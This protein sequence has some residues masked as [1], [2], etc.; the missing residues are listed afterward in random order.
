L[1]PFRWSPPAAPKWTLADSEGQNMGS[2][3]FD[4]QPHL[5]IFYLGHGCLHC[6][7]Q[8]QKFAPRIADF[9]NAGIEVV[10]ISSDGEAGLQDSIAN[11]E[12]DLHFRLASNESLDVFKQFRAYDDFEGQ[13]LHGTFLVDGKGRIRWQDISYQPFMDDEF[14]L[15]ESKRL[16]ADEL[17]KKPIASATMLESEA[18][19]QAE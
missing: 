14:L 13:A 17:G 5:I 8:L 2:S 6:A 11:F 16:L 18:V 12:G 3:E 15:E 1:G 10:A 19:V 9:E 7:E 4:G